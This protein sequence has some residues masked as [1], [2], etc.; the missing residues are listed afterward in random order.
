M[1]STLKKVKSMQEMCMSYGVDEQSQLYK[2]IVSFM[3]IGLKSNVIRS[4]PETNI[5]GEWFQ[6]EIMS[7]IDAL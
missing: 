4:V 7:C 2:R 6:G 3:I 1:K 5:K